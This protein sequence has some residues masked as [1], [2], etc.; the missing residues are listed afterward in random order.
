MFP[1]IEVINLAHRVD[2]LTLLRCELD[3]IGVSLEDRRI[4]VPKAP[5]VDDANGFPSRSVYG[6]FLS[7]LDIIRRALHDQAESVLIVEDDA[8]FRRHA[9]DSRFISRLADQI[10]A[11][12][13][14]LCFLG[15]PLSRA[16]PRQGDHPLVS[17]H[18]PFKWAHCYA[19]SGRFLPT[20]VRYLEESAERPR[21]HKE[22][23]KMYI[24]GALCHFR[25]LR[26]D[27]R[28]LV[29]SPALSIQRG[30]PSSI[31]G[32]KWYDRLP[33]LDKGVDSLRRVRDELW[34]RTGVQLHRGNV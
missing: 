22:G 11:V 16:L 30:S 1:R 29:C 9:A 27:I 12:D 4:S 26:P 32:S 23:G 17:Y 21:G 10:H 2:R 14:D 5:I 18:R 28:T 33:V 19:V 13:W 15:H 6:N 34:R 31:A 3:R 20:L 25:L 7:H 8:I 24:D